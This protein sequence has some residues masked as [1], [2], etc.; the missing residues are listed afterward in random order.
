MTPGE[1][2]EA[3][4]KLGLSLSEAARILDVDPRTIRKWEAEAGTNA[5]PPN[6]TAARVMEW[7]LA[8]W[9]PPQWPA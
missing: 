3:R 8:G 6:P 4:Q 7:M 5:R 9:R 1:F 2:K